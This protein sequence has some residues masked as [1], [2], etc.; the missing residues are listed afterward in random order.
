[1]F[2]SSCVALRYTP[3]HAKAVDAVLLLRDT[4][5]A[6]AARPGWPPEA[7]WRYPG[8][9]E[10]VLVTC[11]TGERHPK[12]PANGIAGIPVV[13][14]QAAVCDNGMIYVSLAFREGC[15]TLGIDLQLARQG[16]PTDKAHV[17][18]FFDTYES[19]FAC[20]LPGAK[21]R[22]VAG[23]GKDP[24]QEAVYFVSELEDLTY[25]WLA[26]HYQRA[27][28][29]GNRLA[30]DPRRD[31]SPNEMF[32]EGVARS[33]FVH[34]PPMG[35][36]YYAL[37]P[38]R[39]RKVNQ[40]GVKLFG[41][42]YDGAALEPYRPKVL[43]TERPRDDR[44]LIRFDPRDLRRVWFRHPASG[45]FATLD[46]RGL[47]ATAVPFGDLELAWCKAN[48]LADSGL[49][50]PRPSW[51]R[52]SVASCAATRPTLRPSGP[53]S[54]CAR[55]PY[56]T[57]HPRPR[58]GAPRPCWPPTWPTTLTGTWIPTTS[59]PCPCSWLISRSEM[60]RHSAA[61]RAS[62]HC[63]RTPPCLRHRRPRRSGTAT[64]TPRPARRRRCSAIGEYRRLADAERHAYDEA[65]LAHHGA[66]A[67]ISTPWMRDVH[68]KLGRQLGA[69]LRNLQP[70]ARR[71]SVISAKANRGKT[72]ICMTFA[73]HY[74]RSV[75]ARYGQRTPEG[76]RLIPVVYVTLPD[77]CRTKWLDLAICEFYAVQLPGQPTKTTS[78][79]PSN[80]WPGSP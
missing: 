26:L 15:A 44:H 1:M 47:G 62:R 29:E 20:D 37:L 4:V 63:H 17:E 71:G 35:D 41:L 79:G 10:S 32:D 22:D 57:R 39:A 58:I 31:L 23:R 30:C 14:P 68:T 19:T 24:E 49:G 69:N 42:W 38:R 2:S 56:S 5:T 75:F 40:R 9:P 55:R 60:A 65:R 3:I 7:L 6:K 74:Q 11:L 48:L 73:K 78:C 34:V 51:R 72:T 28:S 36:L 50:P 77:D 52:C 25:E 70:G 53:R 13:R 43:R 45:E 76:N 61:G 54:S 21:G 80:G 16:T 8:I 64:S 46:W 27:P 18:R 59:S 12:G 33:G 66:F 67:P